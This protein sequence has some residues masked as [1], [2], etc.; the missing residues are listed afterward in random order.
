MFFPR[1]FWCKILFVQYDSDGWFFFWVHVF[2]KHLNDA[3]KLD[4]GTKNSILKER[5]C[6]NRKLALLRVK[7][8]WLLNSLTVRCGWN[9]GA[10]FAPQPVDFT[11]VKQQFYIFLSKRKDRDQFFFI[12]YKIIYTK[13]F[14]H[15]NTFT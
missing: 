15:R 8:L 5:H 14:V 9:F 7:F 3:L 4:K 12:K 11:T 13:F 1:N 2:C 6:W 10:F